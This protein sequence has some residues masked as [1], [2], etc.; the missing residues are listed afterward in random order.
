MDAELIQLRGFEKAA[1]TRLETF[2][3]TVSSE[4]SIISIKGRLV[5]LEEIFSKMLEYESALPQEQSEW[6]R[7][8]IGISMQRSTSEVVGANNA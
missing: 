5:K 2:L 7:S 1:L 4:I 8:K 3:T 6:S